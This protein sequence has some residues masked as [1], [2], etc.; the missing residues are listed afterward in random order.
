MSRAALEPLF[1]SPEWA[2][3]VEELNRFVAIE[4]PRRR[5]FHDSDHRGKIRSEAAAGFEIPVRAR[6]EDAANLTALRNLLA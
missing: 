6:C 5:Q 1:S 3:H 4:H 2:E